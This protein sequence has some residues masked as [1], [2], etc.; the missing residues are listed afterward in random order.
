VLT[1]DNHEG[2][3]LDALTRGDTANAMAYALLALAAAVDRLAE[4][5]AARP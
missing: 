5:Q 1:P 4:E 3:A 2:S